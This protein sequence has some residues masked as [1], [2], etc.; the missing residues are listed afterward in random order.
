MNTSWSDITKLYNDIEKRVRVQPLSNHVPLS[1]VAHEGG[2]GERYALT[3]SI[4]K[5]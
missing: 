4:I 5:E 2:E 1:Q 3:L